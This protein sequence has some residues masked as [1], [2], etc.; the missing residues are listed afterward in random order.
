VC[1]CRACQSFDW[2][3]LFGT[4]SLELYRSR[5]GTARPEQ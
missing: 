2:N 4:N 1:D 3:L 5:G